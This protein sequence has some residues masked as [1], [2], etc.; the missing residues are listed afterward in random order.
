MQFQLHQHQL[1][2]QL[3]Q[4]QQQFLARKQVTTSYQPS[5]N[6]FLFDLCGITNKPQTIP[7]I[8]SQRTSVQRSVSQP[9]CAVSKEKSLFR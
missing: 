5:E 6:E 3:H 8:Q 4:Q 2:H 9:E 7:Q 1:Q